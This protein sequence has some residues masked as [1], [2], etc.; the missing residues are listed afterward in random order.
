ME[1]V[2]SF[3]EKWLVEIL[4]VIGFVLLFLLILPFV[5]IFDGDTFYYIAKA[6]RMLSTGDIF[7]TS[8]LMAKPVLVLWMYALFYKV[9]GVNLFARSILT[10]SIIA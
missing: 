10:F 2:K 6:R 1:K 5:P 4:L 3:V 7:N 8:T 9:F